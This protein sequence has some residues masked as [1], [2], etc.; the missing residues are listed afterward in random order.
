MFRGC[1]EHTIDDKGRLSIPARFRE[2]LE[3]T[4]SAPLYLTRH[5]DCLVAYPADEWRAL[6]A[7]INE[8]PAF[9]PKIQAFRRFFYAP[10]Q[11]CPVDKAGR[12]LVPPTLRSYAGLD[13]QVV[14]AGMGRNFEIWAK[15]RYDAAMD[16]VAAQFDEIAGAVGGLGL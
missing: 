12:I 16:A 6:E 7:R 1:F 13:R 3:T 8:L 9:D 4:F 2:A 11:E 14:L 10:A 5:K 15:E